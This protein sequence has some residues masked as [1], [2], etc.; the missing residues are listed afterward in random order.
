MLRNL[1]STLW[2]DV[3]DGKSVLVSAS[4]PQNPIKAL[5]MAVVDGTLVVEQ[6]ETRRVSRNSVHVE[7]NVV[8]T[9]DGGHSS[10]TIGGTPDNTHF[11]VEP[12]ALRVSLPRETALSIRGFAG[13]ARIGAMTAPVDLETVSGEIEIRR[14]GTASLAISGGA[15]I[16]VIQIAGSLDLTIDGAGEISVQ[17]GKIPAL[18]LETNGSATVSIGGRVGRADISLNGIAD[19]Q[20]AHVDERPVV[21]ANGI[22]TIEIGN[23]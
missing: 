7:R 19:I 21:D 20:I 5:R 4:G 12:V 15:A 3:H 9:R 11:A 14:L 16:E 13:N 8:I 6:P 10:V 1:H 17:D 23:W 2:I 22:A 18:T